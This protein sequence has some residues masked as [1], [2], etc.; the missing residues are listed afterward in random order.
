MSDPSYKT[1][2][3]AKIIGIHPNTVRLYEKMELISKP[4]RKQNGYRIFYEFH[5]EQFRLA[6]IALQVDVMLSLYNP[7]FDS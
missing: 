3:V 1:S 5:I 2:D 6:R 4:E 7:I